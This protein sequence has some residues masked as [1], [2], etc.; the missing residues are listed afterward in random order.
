MFVSEQLPT[1]AIQRSSETRRVAS[2]KH[3]RA[4]SPRP[5]ILTDLGPLGRKIGLVALA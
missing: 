4:L 2:N 1:P 3:R 5:W